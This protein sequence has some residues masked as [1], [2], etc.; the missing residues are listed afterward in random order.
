MITVCVIVH[1]LKS[2]C[3]C[4][5]RHIL[6]PSDVHK[7]VLSSLV[8]VENFIPE[9]T[10]TGGAL[11]SQLPQR[12]RCCVAIQRHMT[13]DETNCRENGEKYS[14]NCRLKPF[15][16]L[17]PNSHDQSTRFNS[18]S[19]LL[20][21]NPLFHCVQWQVFTGHLKTKTQLNSVFPVVSL[22]TKK[23]WHQKP[24]Q[25]RL[26]DYWEALN[27]HSDHTDYF[28]TVNRDTNSVRLS[29]IEHCGG[30]RDERKQLG[31]PPLVSWQIPPGID[32]LKA[33][34]RIWQGL[35]EERQD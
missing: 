11:Q 28:K 6:I 4:P 10:E 31:V 19:T 21:N 5:H 18:A 29:R 1:Q 15:D 26:I 9:Q 33:D 24:A 16:H 25:N 14:A 22:G 27:D 12:Q 7:K 20:T 32:H 13:Q 8:D 23:L 17:A 35:Q 2:A 3:L 30:S 34:Q